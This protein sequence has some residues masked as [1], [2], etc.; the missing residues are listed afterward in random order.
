MRPRG[1]HLLER[2]MPVSSRMSSGVKAAQT[3]WSV[4]HSA[5]HSDGDAICAAAR[6]APAGK[7]CGRTRAAR[8]STISNSQHTPTDCEILT[9]P[10]HRADGGD[11]CAAARVA[12]AGEAHGRGW[13]ARARRHLRLRPLLLPQRQ[14]A[15]QARHWCIQ[16]HTAFALHLFVHDDERRRTV[17]GGFM[18][19]LPSNAHVQGLNTLAPSASTTLDDE[20]VAK[21]AE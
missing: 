13:A 17:M 9:E 7:E 11:V 20:L 18:W 16:A 5:P 12:P 2:H 15:P 1:R 3:V 19:D 21:G 4:I 6:V 10:S 14:G 8:G